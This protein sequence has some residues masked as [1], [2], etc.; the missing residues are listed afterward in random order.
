M[1]IALVS[2]LFP[3][4]AI[5]GAETVASEL[6]RALHLGGHQVDVVST[7][8]REAVSNHGYRVDEWEGIRVWRIAPW[9]LYW[10]FDKAE[11]RPKG[12]VRAGWHMIDLWN[13][14]VF[15]PL[16]QVFDRIQPDVINTHN[17]D[18]F[19]PALWQAARRHTSAI[20]HTLHD[21]HLICTRA[22]MRRRDGTVCSRRLC[23]LCQAYA[24][25]HSLFRKNVSL[26]I[27]PTR[28]LADLH[29]EFSWRNLPLEVVR[30]AV[31]LPLLNADELPDSGPLRVLFLSRL[32]REKGCETLMSVVPLFNAGSGI[33][34]HVAGSGSYADRFKQLAE[35]PGQVRWHGFV[36]SSSKYDLL[37]STDVFL[38][39]SECHDNAPL[40][41]LEARQSGLRLVGTE[42]GGI[43]ELIGGPQY[44]DLIRPG[45]TQALY[46]LL[47]TLAEN[48]EHV[49]HER[50]RRLAG[51][52]PY[53]FREMAA[54]YE[55]VF[56]S[57]LPN[58]V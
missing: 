47:S 54:D 56:S 31:E 35:R 10:N 30:N 51:I 27:S 44:G 17:I 28:T 12:L 52:A 41:L 50:R 1:R 53:S 45:D 33:E 5:G 21:C 26:L 42:V 24:A 48:A 37:R 40:S 46:T 6:A 8:P 13:P 11:Q 34:F 32:E 19:S 15:G 29:V 23:T 22:T 9:N 4:Y 49:R 25:Y 16:H 3:P 14:S 36:S 20:A 18:G 58:T 57:L 7:C 55:R 39:L 2:A 38:Q 43:P